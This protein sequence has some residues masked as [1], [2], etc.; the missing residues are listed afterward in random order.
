MTD[1]FFEEL[2]TELRLGTSKKGHPFRY[3]T[4]ATTDEEGGPRLRTVV[5]RRVTEDLK[6]FL[7]T[8]QRSTK[9]THIKK[10]KR[11]SLLVYHPKKLLQLKMDA[12][13]RCI[14][15]EDTLKRY[16]SGVPLASRKDY[17][18]VSPPGSPIS[19]PDALS[20][21]EGLD[22]FCILEL[23]PTK[24]EYLKLKRPNHIRVDYTREGNDWKGQ[25]LVP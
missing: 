13:A 25:F 19:N 12:S 10:N 14:T 6:L 1:V 24:I 23:H 5:L 8:D 9:V 15:D 3:M 17:T 11:A 16:W 18:A 4:M 2:V 22:N 20:Y 7:Y 21:S